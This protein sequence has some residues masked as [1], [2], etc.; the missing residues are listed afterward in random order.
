MLWH[1]FAPVVTI[2]SSGVIDQFLSRAKRLDQCTKRTAE[3]G[4]VGEIRYVASLSMIH[5][6]AGSA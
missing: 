5:C 6:T 4:V 3:A 2:I 1:P